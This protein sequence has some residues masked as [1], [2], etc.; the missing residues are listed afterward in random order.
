MYEASQQ[1]GFR[2]M[3]YEDFEQLLQFQIG[4]VRDFNSVARAVRKVDGV[5]AMFFAAIDY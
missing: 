1:S 2:P 4:D 5:F 3:T